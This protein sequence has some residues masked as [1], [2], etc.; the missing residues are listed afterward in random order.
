MNVEFEWCHDRIGIAEVHRVDR[1][2]GNTKGSFHIRVVSRIAV[3]VNFHIRRF[4]RHHQDV[5]MLGII[6]PG[7]KRVVVAASSD[8]IIVMIERH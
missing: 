2:L 6:V 3:K 4:D 5:Q 7:Q 1:P 8:A